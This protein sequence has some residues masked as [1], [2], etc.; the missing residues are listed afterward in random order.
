MKLQKKGLLSGCEHLLTPLTTDQEG[1]L[2]GG[3]GDISGIATY[4]IN[5]EC[6][7]NPCTNIGC[8]NHPCYN[9]ECGNG[10]CSNTDCYIITVP[11]QGSKPTEKS[12]TKAPTKFASGAN[13]CG[14]L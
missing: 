2:R 13:L 12:T 7:N 5:A 9:G 14:L 3:F 6:K 8:T 10:R 11:G 1:N 4:A